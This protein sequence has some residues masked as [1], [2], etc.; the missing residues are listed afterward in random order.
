MRTHI[1]RS[2]AVLIVFVAFIACVHA[3]PDGPDS[4]D[5]MDWHFFAEMGGQ[6]STML[7]SD[8]F[9]QMVSDAKTYQ[10][11][12]QLADC[13]TKTMSAMPR[14]NGNSILPFPQLQPPPPPRSQP[15]PTQPR[16]S[17]QGYTSSADMEMAFLGE[18]FDTSSDPPQ[19]S[20]PAVA[21]ASVYEQEQF[22]VFDNTQPVF[23]NSRR[24]RWNSGQRS[25]PAIP[26]AIPQSS[27]VVQSGLQ[28]QC[29]EYSR[30]A[31]AAANMLLENEYQASQA[32]LEETWMHSAQTNMPSFQQPDLSHQ[33][34]GD[35][36]AQP[37]PAA[38][39]VRSQ[40]KASPTPIP[41]SE[42]HLLSTDVIDNFNYHHGMGS[43]VGSMLGWIG[44]ATTT[45]DR[46]LPRLDTNHLAPPEVTSANHSPSSASTAG[47]SRPGSSRRLKWQMSE[48]GDFVCGWCNAGFNTQGDL[49]HHLRSHQPYASRQHVCSHCEKRFQYRKDL[50]RHLP[51]HDPNRKKFYC[52]YTGC[53]FH[54]TKGFGRQDHLDRHLQ[55]QHRADTPVTARS[56]AVLPST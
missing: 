43:E 37:M 54:H 55:T 6:F 3:Q 9:A 41:R 12:A 19:P 5:D 18:Q 45:G 56:P 33:W 30:S 8:Q 42:P 2:T 29:Q 48:S 20:Y 26:Q 4:M 25:T 16:D 51:K 36:L 40:L 38:Q 32:T 34:A 11:K 53:K 21:S 50:T 31:P 52:H 24:P 35:Q 27:L 7:A 10:T 17:S 28:P 49:T 23:E 44:R 22:G 47:S 15:L 13:C 46:A 1:D 14:S 39:F